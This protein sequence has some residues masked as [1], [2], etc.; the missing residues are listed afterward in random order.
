MNLEFHYYAVYFLCARAGFSED[1]ARVIA[2]SSQH[3]DE[4][5]VPWEADLG[6]ST[7]HTISTQNY[8]F[9]DEDILASVYLPFHFVPGDPVLAAGR[10]TDRA[11]NR[12][13]VTP[14][15]P[16]AKTMLIE[17]LGTRDLFRIGIALHAYADT[18]AH[19]NFTG[20]TEE[21]NVVDPASPLPPAGHLQALRAP[22]DALVL[23]RDDRLSP[24]LE[25]VDNRER[26][27]AA[28]RKIY[29]YLRTFRRETFAD[30]ELVLSDLERL[31]KRD[32]RDLEARVADFCIALDIAPYSRRTWLEEAGIT[33]AREEDSL[34][35]GYNKLQWLKAEIARRA[36]SRESRPVNTSGR[37]EGS[38]LH[39]WDE[40]ARAHLAAAT[41][42]LREGG[43]L[44]E[45]AR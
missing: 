19:Q 26:F 17:A 1:E 31:W 32:A 8:V 5:L 45:A 16:L 3:V 18:W 24:G 38:A 36:R 7:Y 10:R 23:W 33:D 34:V 37:F 44:K 13:I 29:R 9:W 28:A 20:R 35:P 14:D 6:S 43:H 25:F 42:L 2:T 21:A 40:A 22:D 15:S 39:R 11:S 12:F 4:A 27:L 41:R 30:E